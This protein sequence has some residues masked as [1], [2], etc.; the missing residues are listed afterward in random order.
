MR[1]FP[2]PNLSRGWACPVCDTAE[3]KPV[4]L[5]PIPRKQKGNICEAKQVHV[6]CTLV[7]ARSYV[8]ATKGED[9]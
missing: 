8:E 7:V 1:V 6:D 4:I 2:K 9:T 3:E 5:V